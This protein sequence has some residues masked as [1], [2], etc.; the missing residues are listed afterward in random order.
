LDETITDLAQFIPQIKS[1]AIVPVG[2]TKFREGLFDLKSFT[3]RGAIEV[4]QQVESYQEQFRRE[5]N[6]NFVYLADEF[7]LLADEELPEQNYYDD[8]PQLENGVGQVRLFRDQFLAL[9]EDLPTKLAEPLKVTLITAKLGA[10]ALD[11]IIDE[12][13]RI[14][15]LE[16]EPFVIENHFFGPEVTVTG[17]LT[18]TDILDQL[19]EA[20]TEL[21]DLVIVPEVVL[22]DNDLFLDDLS[23]TEFK[24]KLNVEVIKVGTDVEDFI[25]NLLGK[26]EVI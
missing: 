16:V 19:Q 2:L 25:E 11:P 20:E 23:W 1:L 6:N 7:Y 9:K 15:N 21:G 18:G 12:L 26:R 3:A 8:F 24:S 4:I 13:L 5:N 14:K 10:Q 17:L 22:N